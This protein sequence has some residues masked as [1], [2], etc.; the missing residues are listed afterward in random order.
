MT[1]TNG[2]T[3]LRVI[4]ANPDEDTLQLGGNM[5]T[6]INRRCKLCGG[7]VDML[8]TELGECK[9][10]EDGL[11]TLIPLSEEERMSSLR[12][13]EAEQAVH[14]LLRFIDRDPDTDEN[15]RDTPR[16]V[17]DSLQQMT[18]GRKQKAEDILKTTFEEQGTDQMIICRDIP[19]SSLCSHHLL[20]F[21][22]TVDIGY[23][24]AAIRDGKYLIVGLSKLAR[25]VDCY[26]TRL[27]IQELMTSEIANAVMDHLKAR[28]AA[29]VVRAIHSCMC[30]RGVKKAG[31]E[32][33]TSAMLGLF[34]EEAV[35][36]AEFLSLCRK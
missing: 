25:L 18:C 8:N 14:T 9:V 21:H 33:I 26:A 15:V 2:Q 23:L 13:A 24:P 1:S 7:V 20:V 11:H 3:L 28:G 19:F 30:H 34:R 36:R 5:N 35:A 4:A 6:L 22:G 29:V 27:Q 16:R 31:A 17:V 32:M 10:A 12:R